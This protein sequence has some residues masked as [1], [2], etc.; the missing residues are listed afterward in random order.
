MT[1]SVAGAAYLEGYRDALQ[2]VAYPEDLPL[3]I[4]IAYL[5]MFAVCPVVGFALLGI[6][7]W[8]SG[9]L[10]RGAAVLLIA[11]G[12]LT[13]AS[14]LGTL[15]DLVQIAL[16]IVADGWVAW[17]IWKQPFTGAVEAEAQPRVR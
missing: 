10:P 2:A 16:L 6:A 15:T 13:Q 4:Q 14:K 3:L 5:V 7:V 1:N 17:A 11:N 12:L 8:L 9:T